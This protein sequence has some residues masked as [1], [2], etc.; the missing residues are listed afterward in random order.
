MLVY[1][2]FR[3]PTETIANPRQ[4]PPSLDRHWNKAFTPGIVRR[5]P[6]V[7]AFHPAVA[8]QRAFQQQLR[9]THQREV[10]V[11]NTANDE[12][13]QD[14]AQRTRTH[15]GE[16]NV[17]VVAVAAA[18]PTRTT[19]RRRGREPLSAAPLPPPPPAPA[20]QPPRPSPLARSSKA[21]LGARPDSNSSSSSSSRVDVA[22]RA[23]RLTA[24]QWVCMEAWMAR[25]RQ[26]LG[27]MVCDCLG[28]GGTFSSTQNRIREAVLP[29]GRGQA[30]DQSSGPLGNIPR[31]W[32]SV[33]S[34]EGVSGEEGLRGHV[35][36]DSDTKRRQG[37]RVASET[38]ERRTRGWD[39]H[40][41][42][43]AALAIE[44]VMWTLATEHERSTTCAAIARSRNQVHPRGGK[45]DLGAEHGRSCGYDG[46]KRTHTD[47]SLVTTE[48]GVSLPRARRFVKASRLIDGIHVL[49]ADVD[50]AFKRWGE[51][52]RERRV[53]AAIPV[54]ADVRATLPA[55]QLS[56]ER[57]DRRNRCEAVGC[58]ELARY[59]DILPMATA[60]LCRKHKM[61]GMVDVGGRR[62]E[63]LLVC[64][65]L[66]IFFQAAS[67]ATVS[68]SWLLARVWRE[69]DLYP[70]YRAFFAYMYVLTA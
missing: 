59:G 58:S 35:E 17:P 12:Q 60:K 70:L 52:E 36:L 38:C 25:A 54:S 48:L 3:G 51:I 53:A 31:V 14:Q 11:A 28:S 15:R 33:P 5:S 13:P 40:L 57:A 1:Q 9:R 22:A 20:P 32:R 23:G 24:Q 44:A 61:D 69:Q 27:P 43:K 8:K 18:K 10:P 21:D 67:S 65:E 64:A 62:C 30:L 4:P 42:Q 37:P 16:K 63:L 55:D 19:A 29:R 41:S 46:R 7:D 68:S 26:S 66:P 34:E 49:E 6:L 50:L 2:R 45:V 47:S 56:T 39:D